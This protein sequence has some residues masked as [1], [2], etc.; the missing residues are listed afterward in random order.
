MAHVDYFMV[1]N[2][3]A[4]VLRSLV[5]LQEAVV[6]HTRGQRLRG[7]Q[8]PACGSRLRNGLEARAG[9]GPSSF[10]SKGCKSRKIY[11]VMSQRA[12]CLATHT[13]EFEIKGAEPMR[14]PTA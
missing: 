1:H 4:C 8:P 7:Q 6:L 5:T 11:T 10:V 3:N 9:M 2:V 13:L 12:S 14:V